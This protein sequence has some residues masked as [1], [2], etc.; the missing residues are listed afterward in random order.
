[1]GCL[2]GGRVVCL[3]VGCGFGGFGVGRVFVVW[4]SWVVLCGGCGLRCVGFFCVGCGVYPWN[5]F[6]WL[7]FD[8]RRVWWGL[9]EC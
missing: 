4:V 8:F 1:M 2:G 6:L 3:C 9:V 5:G 7:R